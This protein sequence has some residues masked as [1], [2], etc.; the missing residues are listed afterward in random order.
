MNPRPLVL[1][2]IS[3]T[4]DHGSALRLNDVATTIA[5]DN[6]VVYTLAFSP[7]LST[8]LDWMRGYYNDDPPGIGL[9]FMGMDAARKNIPK[10]IAAM[11]GGEYELFKSGNGFETRMN[12]FDNHLYN[13]YLLSFEPK[14]PHPGLHEVRVRLQR[15]AGATVLARNSYWVAPKLPANVS[16]R[17]R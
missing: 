6:I 17:S 13:R 10:A 1:L 11:T 2:L 9:I 4:Q 12:Q 3:E 8:V 7:A 16:S 5:N 15:P 14:D